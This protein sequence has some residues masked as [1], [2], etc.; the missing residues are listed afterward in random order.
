MTFINPAE[1]GRTM[2][3]GSVYGARKVYEVITSAVLDVVQSV[4]G[5]GEVEKTG[6][7]VTE[8]RTYHIIADSEELARALYFKRWGSEFQRHTLISIKPLFVIDAEIN[9]RNN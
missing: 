7:R 9:Y 1:P 5:T 8:Q 6:Q 3:N 2:H 4:Y